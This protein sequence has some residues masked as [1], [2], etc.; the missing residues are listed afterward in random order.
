MGCLPGEYDIVID[1][2]MPPEQNR[3]RNVADALKE[4]FQKKLDELEEQ[5]VITKVDT[6]TPWISYCLAV[7]KPNGSECALINLT[8]TIQF[9]GII[10][11]WRP[12]T[13]FCQH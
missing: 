7:R 12:P 10:S 4:D 8:R 9:S 5:G 13:K 3:P 1:K 6:Q 2:E 11:R